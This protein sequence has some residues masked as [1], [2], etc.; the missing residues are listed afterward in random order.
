MGFRKSTDIFNQS[1]IYQ[2]IASKYIS[3][4][5]GIYLLTTLQGSLN[6]FLSLGNMGMAKTFGWTDN[7][8]KGNFAEITSKRILQNFSS[9]TRES[10]LGVAIML[11]LILQYLGAFYGI[12]KLVKARQYMFASLLILT[13]IYFSAVTGVLGNYRFKLP[14][15]PL[16][17]I[18]A[19]YGYSMLKIM[20]GDGENTNLQKN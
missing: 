17:C 19:G 5:K 2:K 18:A 1:E 16:L 7:A 4:H 15:I 13:V 14:V 3:T 8:P 10:L 6:M 9:N 20:R 11:I 12:I